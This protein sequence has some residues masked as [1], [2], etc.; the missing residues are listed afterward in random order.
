MTFD[1]GQKQTKGAVSE[2][3]EHVDIAL[4]VC[5]CFSEEPADL[6]RHIALRVRAYGH[7]KEGERQRS[8]ESVGSGKFA[9]QEKL[10]CFKAED[11]CF[12]LIQKEPDAVAEH[13][14][15][16]DHFF[17]NANLD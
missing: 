3:T 2:V 13:R 6:N 1:T 15:E 8:F 11:A 14:I 7:A 9:L 5:H 12:R 10:Q 16:I 17:R 4:D